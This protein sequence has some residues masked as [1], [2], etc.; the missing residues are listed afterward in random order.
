MRIKPLSQ[1]QHAEHPPYRSVPG[2]QDQ[3]VPS[4]P[5]RGLAGQRLALRLS[6]HPPVRFTKQVTL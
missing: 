4:T 5:G 6:L 3:P 1:L 2:H